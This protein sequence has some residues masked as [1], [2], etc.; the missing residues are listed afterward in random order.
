MFAKLHMLTKCNDKKKDVKHTI[1][2]SQLQ[3]PN[4]IKIYIPYKLGKSLFHLTLGTR[5]NFMKVRW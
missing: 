1:Y 2:D 3:R 4:L 5:P